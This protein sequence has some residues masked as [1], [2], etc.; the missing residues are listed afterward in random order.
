VRGIKKIEASFLYKTQLMVTSIAKNSGNVRYRSQTLFPNI[1]F[2]DDNRADNHLIASYIKLDNIPIIPHFKRNAL[3]AI[4]CLKGLK[5]SNFPDIIF[6]DINM[7]LKDGFEFVQDFT[8]QFP[9]TDTDI[10]IMSSFI[11]PSDREKVDK[12]DII[13]DYVEK[14]L[15]TEFINQLINKL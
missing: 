1:F 6:V 11:R 15:T 4:E 14:P 5:N 3:H 13:K 9:G 7:P 8:L 12:Y 2:I 10:Y